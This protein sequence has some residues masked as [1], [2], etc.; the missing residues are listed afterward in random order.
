M[1]ELD[2]WRAVAMLQGD[3]L[4]HSFDELKS[5]DDFKAGFAFITEGESFVSLP[6][7]GY[8]IFHE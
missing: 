5:C 6:W 8:T 7:L 1:N 2:V 4:G 3:G